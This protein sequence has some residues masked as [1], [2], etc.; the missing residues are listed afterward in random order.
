MKDRVSARRRDEMSLV[1]GRVMEG[2]N[3]EVKEWVGKQR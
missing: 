3:K 2:M 1:K